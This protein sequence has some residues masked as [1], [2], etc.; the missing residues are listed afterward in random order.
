MKR[1]T[2]IPKIPEQKKEV[3][4][5][6]IIMKAKATAQFDRAVEKYETH[7]R[8]RSIYPWLKQCKYHDFVNYFDNID[9]GSIFILKVIH[10]TIPDLNQNAKD[11]FCN[12]PKKTPLYHSHKVDN[13]HLDIVKNVAKTLNPDITF[14]DS[15]EWWEIGGK[16]GYRIFGVYSQVEP[17]FYPLF[18]DWHHLIYPDT[19]HNYKDYLKYS[20]S[21]E[22]G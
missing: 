3:R 17:A 16:Q 21:L 1:T 4:S 15:L 14:D 18:A 9:N 8:F 19:E 6:G 2:E 13:E 10:E 20:C 12:N 11:I 7:F 5:S 22:N